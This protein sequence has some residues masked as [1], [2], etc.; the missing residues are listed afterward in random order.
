[1]RRDPQDVRSRR[2]ERQA[3]T[4]LGSALRNAV[5]DDTEDADQ[6]A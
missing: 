3:D 6:R 1:M 4:E 2:A 5:N